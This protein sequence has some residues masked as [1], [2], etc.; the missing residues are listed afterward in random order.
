MGTDTSK[1]THMVK[2]VTVVDSK[3]FEGS[4]LLTGRCY[5]AEICVILLLLRNPFRWYPFLQN[6]FGLQ[7]SKPWT[8]V[9][10][11]RPENENFNFGQK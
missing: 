8:I 6:L 3:T 11:F 10:G 2:D 5:E 1:C 9:H 7:K 4:Y